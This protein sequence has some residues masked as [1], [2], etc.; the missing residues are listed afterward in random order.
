MT[1]CQSTAREIWKCVA[2]EPDYLVDDFDIKDLASE[3][4]DPNVVV[5]AKCPDRAGR[6]GYTFGFRQPQNCKLEV[7]SKVEVIPVLHNFTPV[8]PHSRKVDRVV[9]L[10]GHS[11]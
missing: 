10:P 5:G 1:G 7:V 6:F 11:F 2:F 9:P 8:A 4:H 3:V